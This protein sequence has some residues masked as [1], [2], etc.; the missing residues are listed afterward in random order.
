VRPRLLSNL[1][2]Y[3]LKAAL[4]CPILSTAIFSTASISTW[5]L[6]KVGAGASRQ[7]GR[8]SGPTVWSPTLFLF[9]GARLSSR[10][11]FAARHI[12]LSRISSRQQEVISSMR[13]I[14]YASAQRMQVVVVFEFVALT[15]PFDDWQKTSVAL[16]MRRIRVHNTIDRLMRM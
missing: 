12:S 14:H 9:L 1:V 7:P 5:E 2:I 10:N 13:L 11:L 16:S 4:I 15:C 8:H 6:I 3:R